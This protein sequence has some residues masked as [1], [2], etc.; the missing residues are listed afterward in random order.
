LG[1]ESIQE[2]FLKLYLLTKK[3]SLAILDDYHG[4]AAEYF[5]DLDLP[6]SH[7]PLTLDPGKP[8]DLA[9]LIERLKPY[10][11]I[12]TMRERTPF[13]R[14]LLSQLPNLKLLV[15]TGMRNL[16]IDLQAAREFGITVCGTKSVYVTERKMVNHDTTT[17]HTWALIL[18]LA[19]RITSD[20]R[21]LQSEP[22]TWQSDFILTLAGKTLGVMGL[23]RL[24]TRVARIAIQSFGM[25]VI[26][27]SENL[28]QEK[29]NETGLDIRVVS[30]EEL[31]RDSDVVSLHLVSSDRTQGIVGKKELEMMKGFLVNTSRGPLINEDDLYECLQRGGIK[32]AALDV[33]WEEPLSETSKWRTQWGVDGKSILIMSPHMGY[34]DKD[35]MNAWYKEQVD[36]VKSWQKGEIINQMN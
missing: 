33:W 17:Q 1:K 28:T 24:G 3:M 36:V 2:K 12:S 10:T 18:A 22:R 30:K 31:F 20:D 34:V 19:C 29:A 4:L 16:G 26:A 27:W 9:Q 35:V 32:G 11:I 13:F 21:A 8:S 23:G 15:T 14:E 5:Q 7:Y 6:K 25:K